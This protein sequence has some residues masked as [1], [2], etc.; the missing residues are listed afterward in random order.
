MRQISDPLGSKHTMLSNVRFIEYFYQMSVLSGFV[1]DDF[2]LAQYSICTKYQILTVQN[3]QCYQIFVL[4]NDFTR[5]PFYL[6]FFLNQ[7]YAPD[8]ILSVQNTQCYQMSVFVWICRHWFSFPW[9]AINRR[10]RLSFE[11]S[12]EYRAKNTSWTCFVTSSCLF[13]MT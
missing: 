12:K 2:F 1:D 7:F 6:D 10:L 11:P 13:R 8:M 9:S 5:C 3:T 4:L